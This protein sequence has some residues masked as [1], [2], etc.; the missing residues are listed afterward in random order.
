MKSIVETTLDLQI[1]EL[2]MKSDIRRSP[3]LH[4]PPRRSPRIKEQKS[5]PVVPQSHPEKQIQN[6][7]EPGYHD[8]K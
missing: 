4:P 7:N 6:Q 1:L 2:K 3:R 8:G 5:F